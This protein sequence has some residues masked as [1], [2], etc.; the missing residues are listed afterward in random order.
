MF[1]IADEHHLLLLLCFSASLSADS[2]TELVID[3]GSENEGT[4]ES[5]DA[6]LS[7]EKDEALREEQQEISFKASI[8]S[9]ILGGFALNEEQDAENS[10]EET[11]ASPPSDSSICLRHSTLSVSPKQSSSAS[12]R[13]SA[14]NRSESNSEPK[15]TSPSRR[16]A[17]QKNRS[18]MKKSKT[19]ENDSSDAS[20]PSAVVA[21]GKASRKRSKKSDDTSVGESVSKRSKPEQQIADDKTE[22]T[23][24]TRSISEVKAVKSSSVR[25][26][27]KPNSKQVSSSS[28]D[29][30]PLS[31]IS[32]HVSDKKLASP[33]SSKILLLSEVKVK[34]LPN[35]PSGEKTADKSQPISSNVEDGR[36]TSSE[37]SDHQKSKDILGQILDMQKT[38]KDTMPEK[39]NLKKSVHSEQFKTIVPSLPVPDDNYE[40]VANVYLIIVFIF[41][42]RVFSR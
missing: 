15:I 21:R 28:D 16:S 32:K 6:P 18:K 20:L 30:M 36:P 17:R 31:Q 38:R 9:N 22:K 2:E 27:K 14:R 34:S 33:K 24:K 13:R 26:G 39:I 37:N 42:T 35:P 29:D 3:T 40:L 4:I 10:P 5:T 23:R 41:T 8:P 11:P 25:S 1:E 12:V 19:C 7:E